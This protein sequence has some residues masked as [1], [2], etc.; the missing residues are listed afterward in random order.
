M[1]IFFFFFYEESEGSVLTVNHKRN[2]PRQSGVFKEKEDVPNRVQSV[3]SLSPSLHH[4][5]DYSRFPKVKQPVCCWWLISPIKNDA[6]TLKN[7]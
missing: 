7:D 2:I 1:R 3:T 4:N 5:L 6:K